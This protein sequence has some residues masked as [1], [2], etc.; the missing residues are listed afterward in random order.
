MSEPFST[1][2]DSIAKVDRRMRNLI[3]QNAEM[4]KANRELRATVNGL[5]RL[6]SINQVYNPIAEEEFV[7][8][9]NEQVTS[10]K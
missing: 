10:S 8:V 4:A 6:A 5:N 9:F 7:K 1:Y 2:L 3:K